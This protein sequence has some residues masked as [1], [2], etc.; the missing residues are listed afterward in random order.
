LAPTAVNESYLGV[1]VGQIGCGSFDNGAVEL[2]VERGALSVV[3]QKL[4]NLT[5]GTVSPINAVS[6][7]GFSLRVDL[8]SF[9]DSKK[10]FANLIVCP[11]R[12]Q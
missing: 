4:V 12:I 5:H 7:T 11:D 9:G 3:Q 6:L 8:D 2:T 1:F 10:I